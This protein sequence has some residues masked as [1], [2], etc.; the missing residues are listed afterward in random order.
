MS[1]LCDLIAKLHFS[2][3]FFFRNVEFVVM[4]DKTWLRPLFKSVVLCFPMTLTIQGRTLLTNS[5]SFAP[6]IRAVGLTLYMLMV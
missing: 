5:A 3:A 2:L 1:N 4:F 6:L